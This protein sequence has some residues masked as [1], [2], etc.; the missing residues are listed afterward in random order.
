MKNKLLLLLAFLLGGVSVMANSGEKNKKEEPDV[1]G[2]V[3]N[4]ENKKPL[5]DV[6]I[7]AYNAAKKEK[8]V[9]TDG[10]GNYSLIDLKPGTLYRLVFE[11]DGYKKVTKDKLFLKTAE[12]FVLNVEME[13]DELAFFDLMPSPHLF[14]DGS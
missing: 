7:I 10:T 8:I 12:K 2:T 5:R 13:E 1:N 4:A 11:K 14:S 3:V 9:L 6:S